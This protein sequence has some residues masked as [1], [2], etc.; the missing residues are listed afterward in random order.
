MVDSTTASHDTGRMGTR[1]PA[2]IAVIITML[3]GIGF[4]VIGEPNRLY[5]IG[6][7]LLVTAAWVAVGMLNNRRR[8]EAR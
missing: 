5:V 4:A 6:G 1:T 7:A 8:D 2:L 3:Y